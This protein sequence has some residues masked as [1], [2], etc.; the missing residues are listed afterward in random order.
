M[1]IFILDRFRPVFGRR[2]FRHFFFFV[3][4]VVPGCFFFLSDSL[5][6][7]VIF[8]EIVFQKNSLNPHFGFVLG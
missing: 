4:V 7:G 6:F 5:G 8:R 1:A 3:G 2:G